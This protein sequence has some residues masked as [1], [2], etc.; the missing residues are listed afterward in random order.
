MLLLPFNTCTFSNKLNA[1]NC[2]A[3]W[4]ALVDPFEENFDAKSEDTLQFIGCFTQCCIETGVM[5]DFNYIIS[6]SSPPSDINMTDSTEWSK[7]LASPAR[8]NTGNLLIDSSTA[9][10][11]KVK[12]MRNSI[13]RDL[14]SVKTAPD[15]KKNPDEAQKL[16]S[17]QNR[18]WI[19]SLLQNS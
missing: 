18:Q 14:E 2:A 17:L 3:Q 6:E 11:E 4:K 12:A 8:F 1:D 16:V 10:L 19:Y 13:C 5:A 9:T 15:P 7:W